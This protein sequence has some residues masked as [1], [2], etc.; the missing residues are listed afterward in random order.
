MASRAQLRG[1]NRAQR[2]PNT[3]NANHYRRPLPNRRTRDQVGVIQRMKRVVGKAFGNTDAQWAGVLKAI[4]NRG[5]RSNDFTRVETVACVIRD[6]SIGKQIRQPR[7]AR[8]DMR[9]RRRIRQGTFQ[10][11]RLQEQRENRVE[12]CSCGQTAEAL[13]DSAH[14]FG[15]R[16]G[17]SRVAEN[18]EL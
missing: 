12:R 9:W 2:R 6:G 17:P 4:E 14:Q 10:L 16:G 3:A 18:V 13:A 15:W 8:A 1:H 5:C 11:S 7:R